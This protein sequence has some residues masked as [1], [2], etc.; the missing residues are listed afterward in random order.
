MKNILFMLIILGVC[1][2]KKESEPVNKLITGLDPTVR[3]PQADTTG[4]LAYIQG[5][6][7]GEPFSI[8]DNKD[9]FTLIDGASDRFGSDYNKEWFQAFPDGAI[10]PAWF[11]EQTEKMN[12]KWSIRFDLPA[13]SSTRG[14]G[15]FV[16]YKKKYTTPAIFNNIGERK[17]P[18]NWDVFDIAI[19]RTD[20][21]N[22]QPNTFGITTFTGNVEETKLLQKDSYIK[23]VSV[24]KFAF[25]PNSDFHYELIYEFD[26]KLKSGANILHLTKG[27]MKTWLVSIKL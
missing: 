9:S 4:A 1:S 5:F 17:G 25:V 7:D 3:L 27:R 14:A 12:K 6:I 23:L 13:Y 2:C 15:E 26:V 21:F 22:G 18:S 16:S 20:F 8:V 10:I 19:W 11:F 24:R